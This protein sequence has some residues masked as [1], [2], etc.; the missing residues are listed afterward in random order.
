[1]TPGNEQRARDWYATHRRHVNKMLASSGLRPLDIAIEPTGSDAM[2]PERWKEM[3]WRWF[4]GLG[5]A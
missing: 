4:L 1:M 3:H 5:Q 2:H